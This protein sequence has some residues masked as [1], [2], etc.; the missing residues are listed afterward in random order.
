MFVAVSYLPIYFQAI[1]NASALSSGLMVMPLILGY[2]VT[3]IISGVMTNITE[4]YN[5][6][7]FL[8][9][10][11][12]SVGAGLVSTFDVNTPQSKWI[13]Y[14][15]LLGI[16][17]GFG[18]QQPNICAQNVLGDTE[19]PFGVAFINMMQMR[20]CVAVSQNLFLNE[21]ATGVA[22]V[23]PGFDTRKII[24]RGVTDFSNL[25]SP[26]QPSHV[27]PVY[28][29]VLGTVYLIMTGLCVATLLGAAWCSVA[30]HNEEREPG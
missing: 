30:L 6:S 8:C 29:H 21:L 11:F 18:L 22:E 15:A 7:M 26:N 9:A 23:L 10:V 20:I 2:L 1:R 4:Y 14:Q 25:F 5:P 28:A 12:A 27:M 16:G 3:A 24:E 17:I 13:G 19:V